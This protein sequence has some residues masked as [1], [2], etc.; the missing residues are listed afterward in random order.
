[1]KTALVILF[2]I[3]L[4]ASPIYFLAAAQNVTEAAPRGAAA[5]KRI[6]VAGVPN[7]AQVDEHLYRG[8]QPRSPG[9]RALKEIGVT[10]IVDLRDEQKSRIAWEQRTSEGLGLRFVN[11]PVNGWAPPSDQQVALFLKIF[12]DDPQAKVFV[13]CQFGDDR[14]GVFVATYRIAVDKYSAGEA[15]REMREFGFNSSWHRNMSA[16]VRS[17]PEHLETAPALAEFK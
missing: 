7:A 10:T 8:A 12:R 9:L 1:M 2:A 5:A 4:A 13:H 14:T 15:I 16:F 11:I 3:F 6:Y 17:F